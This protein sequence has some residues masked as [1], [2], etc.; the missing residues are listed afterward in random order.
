MYTFKYYF[1]VS[2]TKIRVCQS[3]YLSTLDITNTRL[4]TYYAT[5]NQSTGTPSA[6][7][8][9]KHVKKKIADE[10]RD[11]IRSHINSFNRV[12]SQYCRAKSGRQYLDSGLSLGR[13]YDMF[14]E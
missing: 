13:M 11:A 7:K 10:H 6:S 1:T 2:S 8:R 12:E 9:G 5:R 14:C 4:K 3:F